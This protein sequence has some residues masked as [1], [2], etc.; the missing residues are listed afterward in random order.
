MARI[1]TTATQKKTPETVPLEPRTNLVFTR[2]P[3]ALERRVGAIENQV[4][5]IP[6]DNLEATT[7]PTTTDDGSEGYEVGSRWVNLSTNR[8]FVCTDAADGFAVW[9]E[10]TAAG[11][12][13]GGPWASQRFVATAAQ[14]SFIL[15]AAPVT[16]SSIIVA[17]N[18]IA[19]DGAGVDYTV[20]GTTLTWLNNEFSLEAGD[21]VSATYII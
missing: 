13:G 4:D 12:G 20:S 17:I 15:G 1:I 21:I 3:S 8:E 14:V 11:G 5:E 9:V 10:T 6:Q 18:G 7:N 19:A 2:Q 16:T